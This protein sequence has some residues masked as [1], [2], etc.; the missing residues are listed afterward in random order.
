V[1]MSLFSDKY[2]H[3]AKVASFEK[4]V[5]EQV[6]R[7]PGVVSVAA[8]SA[9]PLERGLNT[10]VFR[11]GAY[12]SDPN[13]PLL[14]EYRSISADYFRTLGIPLL[15]G[16]TFSDGDSAESARVAIIN[17]TLARQLWPGQGP[18]GHP[19]MVAEGP[20]ATT[21]PRQVVGVVGD[22]KEIG[23]DEPARATVYVPME[24]V[25]DSFNQMT[26]Y[27]FAASLLVKTAQPLHLDNELREAVSSVDPEEP[28]SSIL[29]MAE[30]T[31]RSVAQQRFFMV[32]MGTFAALA[33]VL[34]TVGIYGVLSQQV[35]QRT[36]EIGIRMAL[37]ASR[38]GVLRHVLGDGLR[39]IL[40][41][42]AAGLAGSFATTKL[43]AG[44]LF[45]VQPHDPA[46]LAVVVVIL[47]AAGLGACYVPAHRAT[48]V[49]PMIALRYE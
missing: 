14:I 40:A 24:Q 38:T 1:R 16:R 39:V 34:A 22:I 33:L 45:G 9:T 21:R 43:L 19:V 36:R 49:D 10:V 7:L 12:S 6:R 3:T 35:S 42:V 37:G 26:N 17:E 32:L 48:R 29:S 8:A 44:L 47:V 30:V 15:A 23:L 46:V 4:Q 13:D 31:S 18:L 25:A 41:G 20:A 27:W 11:S 28:V 5:V 2:Q